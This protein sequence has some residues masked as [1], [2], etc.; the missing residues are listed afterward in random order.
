[1]RCMMNL[2][3]VAALLRNDPCKEQNTTILDAASTPKSFK[4]MVDRSSG[5]IRLFI[6]SE[7]KHERQH[8]R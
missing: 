7:R 3:R 4:T 2:H 1:M 6:S 8:M 5:L